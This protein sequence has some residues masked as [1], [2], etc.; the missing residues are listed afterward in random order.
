MSETKYWVAFNKIPGI[1]RVRFALLEKHFGALEAAWKAS[2]G[3][4]KAAG[5]DQ[6]SVTSVTSTAPKIDPDQEME[7]L[8]TLGVKALTWN[9]L[10]YP[11]RLK[12]IYD[13]PPVLYIRGSAF[14]AD[15]AAIT[16]VGTRRATAYGR[17]VAERLVTDLSRSSI[18]ITSGL[19]KG[20]DAVAHNTALANGGV[21]MAVLACGL[22]MV[23][24]AEHANLARRVMEHGALISDYP[25]GTHPRADYFPR[26][27]RIMSGLTLG[28]L[29][30]EADEA[31]GALITARLALEQDREVFAVPGSILSPQSRGTNKLI[32]QGAKA[33]L[34][35]EDVLEELNLTQVP[36]QMEMAPRVETKDIAPENTVEA[37]LLKYISLE[38]AHI[39]DIRRSSG[40]PVATVSS[41]LAMM[42]L[43]GLVKQVGAMN[44]VRARE[45]QAEYTTR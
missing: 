32:Q 8:Q 2:P 31:S 10:S 15:E 26:R 27:N 30:V 29:V 40:L 9:D 18:T 14:P 16:I 35:Y 25:L 39:D 11:K 7:R 3:E 38:P 45:A 28:T 36:F 19:A 12:E 6:R 20:I 5:L 4:L 1:G 23:Y 42:E 24:P 44:Y 37:N 22:D 34:D 21:T 13:P 41:T 33:V 43:K 17:E